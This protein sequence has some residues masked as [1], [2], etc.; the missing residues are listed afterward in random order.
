MVVGVLGAALPPTIDVP[1]GRTFV[2]VSELP[3]IRTGDGYNGGVFIHAPT[4]EAR[5]LKVEANVQALTTEVA[6]IAPIKVP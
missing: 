3:D 4:N 1:P 5:L 6:A 2:N